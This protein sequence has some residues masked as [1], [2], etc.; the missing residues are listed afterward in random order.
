MVCISPNIKLN[1]SEGFITKLYPKEPN[2]T[3]N[4]LKLNSIIQDQRT[5][6]LTYNQRISNLLTKKFTMEGN[7]YRFIEH[8]NWFKLTRNNKMIQR[9]R[10]EIQELNLGSTYKTRK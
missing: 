8:N 9:L 6:N 4:I 3:L 2:I 7:P 1:S 10:E 5:L